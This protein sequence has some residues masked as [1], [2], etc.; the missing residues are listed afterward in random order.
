MCLF[1]INAWL[2]LFVL[3]HCLLVLFVW[4]YVLLFAFDYFLFDNICKFS[5]AVKKHAKHVT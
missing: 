5:E 1:V 3:C 2:D 4:S